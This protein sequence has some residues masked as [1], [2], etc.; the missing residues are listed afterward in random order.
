VLL[1]PSGNLPEI[2]EQTV[3][4]VRVCVSRH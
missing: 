4:P 2:R 1:A 3:Q